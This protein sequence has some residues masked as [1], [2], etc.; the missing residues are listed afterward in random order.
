VLVSL[1]AK[2]FDRGGAASS[3]AGRRDKGAE[4]Y[5]QDDKAGEDVDGHAAERDMS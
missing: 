1:V 3:M 5:D 4:N 2:D